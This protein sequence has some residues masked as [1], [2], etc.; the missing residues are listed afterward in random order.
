MRERWNQL[1][2]ERKVEA[3]G[4]D[5]SA[6]VV[7]GRSIPVDGAPAEPMDASGRGR[8]IDV[9]SLA[10]SLVAAVLAGDH[11]HAATIARAILAHGV[12]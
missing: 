2:F 7:R 8:T 6:M 1:N 9:A 4:V 5:G 10:T 11:E 3:A 12:T